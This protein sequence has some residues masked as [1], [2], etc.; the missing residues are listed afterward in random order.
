VNHFGEAVIL[1]GGKS[2]RMDFDK[3]LAKINGKYMIEM[4]YEKLAQ[5]FASVKLCADSQERLSVLNLEVIEDKIAGRIGPVA[6]IYSALAQA[7]GPYVFVAACDMPLLNTAHIEFMKNLLTQH[8]YQPQA[9]IPRHGGYIEPLYSFYATG[10]AETFA[11][12]IAQGNFK[13]HDILQR[14]NT[15][16]MA[17][18]YSRMFDENLSMFTNINYKTD[19]ERIS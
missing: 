17:E 12:E 18:K 2:R 4:I 19:L 13:I 11:A 10:L 8:A 16:Y 6:G 1:C 3:S 14:C 9:L 15:L 5:C 7:A